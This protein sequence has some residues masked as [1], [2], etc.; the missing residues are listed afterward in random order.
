[1][2]RAQA[3]P[4]TGVCPCLRLARGEGTVHGHPLRNV[5]E[6][7]RAERNP[8]EE[9]GTPQLSV[10]RVANPLDRATQRIGVDL[11]PQ[12]GLSA[13]PEDAQCVEFAAHEPLHGTEQ[14]GRLEGYPL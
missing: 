5:V 6:G 9:S 1:M 11:T 7:E 14:P 4:H 13:T 8:S 12:V 3:V 2:P 10:H